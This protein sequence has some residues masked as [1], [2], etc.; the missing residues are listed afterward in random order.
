LPARMFLTQERVR[1]QGGQPAQKFNLRHS[2]SKSTSCT[3]NPCLDTQT[4]FRLY[5]KTNQVYCQP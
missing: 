2:Q 4:T 3:Q 1:S 5:C